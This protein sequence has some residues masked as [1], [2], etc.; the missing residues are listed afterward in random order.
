MTQLLA[1][2]IS[3]SLE[4]FTVTGT[5]PSGLAGTTMTLQRLPAISATGR[6]MSSADETIAFQ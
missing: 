5:V 3:D 2:G 4:S 1:F 6:L